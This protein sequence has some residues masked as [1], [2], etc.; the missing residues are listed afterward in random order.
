MGG[1]VLPCS[2]KSPTAGGIAMASEF[3]ELTSCA[4]AGSFEHVHADTSI[5]QPSER[6]VDPWSGD[7]A[8]GVDS[9]FGAAGLTEF[10]DVI[11]DFDENTN[12]I[13]DEP[14]EHE[15]LPS[16]PF[17]DVLQAASQSLPVVSLKPIWEQGVWASIFGDSSGD[18]V[19]EDFIER[20][21]VRPVSSVNVRSVDIESGVVKGKA[22]RVAADYF[23]VVKFKPSVSWQ[24][25]QEAGWQQAV[26]LWH[27]LICRWVLRAPVDCCEM[28]SD[29]FRGRSFVTLKKR[30][31][32]VSKI[33]DFIEREIGCQFP[34]S[35]SDY[36][37]FLRSERNLGAPVSR[38][39]GYNQALNFCLHVLGV[40][41]LRDVATSKRC[42]GAAKPDNTKDRVQAS[43][44]RVGELKTLHDVLYQESSI[45]SSYFAG[46]AL[47]C[48]YARARWGDLMR[49]ERLIVDRDDE[50]VVQYIEVHVGRHK[51]MSSQQHKH[52]FLPMVAPALGVDDHH[53]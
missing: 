44:L 12:I 52:K 35:E 5:Q 15:Q 33:C 47:L 30:A 4:S 36:Y 31:L 7:S 43:P 24:E 48:I 41:E 13:V 19:V 9:E 49:S 29:I 50:N 38:L 32:A 8:V 40:E 25:Q 16:V 2:G 42:I 45:W 51:T 23:D 14:P 26:K 21:F 17:T 18:V 11:P 22:R 6:D 20:S 27:G 1:R 28:L 3:V 39:R 37:M 34:C 53:A 46:C 10:S